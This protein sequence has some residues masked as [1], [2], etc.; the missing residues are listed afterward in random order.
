M[1][2][3]VVATLMITSL[4]LVTS[5]RH[6]A[7]QGDPQPT[8]TRPV[9]GLASSSRT[10]VRSCA[11]ELIARAQLD[12]SQLHRAQCGDCNAA[13]V[14]EVTVRIKTSSISSSRV[15]CQYASARNEIYN[16]VYTIPCRNGRP[17]GNGYAHAYSC[18]P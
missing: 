7:A 13:N 14:N 8:A 17:A 12:N 1:N 9:I 11:R 6:L 3:F 18:A 16:L 10:A 4:L 15:M 5:R 2:K